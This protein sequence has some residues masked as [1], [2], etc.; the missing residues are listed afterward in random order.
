M[1]LCLDTQGPVMLG[2]PRKR[3]VLGAKPEQAP[4]A[5]A[6]ARGGVSRDSQTAGLGDPSAQG[7][8][9]SRYG[10]WPQQG[11]G[12][13]VTQALTPKVGIPLATPT[14]APVSPT[15]LQCSLET[16]RP[17]GEEMLSATSATRGRAEEG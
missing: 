16:W 8:S 11:T 5:W 13:G 12:L 6:N 7:S 3:N 1:H 2:T 4:S 10:Q 9:G 15:Q 17:E 14:G